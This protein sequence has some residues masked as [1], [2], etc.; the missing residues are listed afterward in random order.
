MKLLDDL[1]INKTKKFARYMIGQPQKNSVVTPLL[2]YYQRLQTE[3]YFSVY[4]LVVLILFL[5]HFIFSYDEEKVVALCLLT[6]GVLSYIN[7]SSL[8][9]EGLNQKSNSL[10]LEFKTLFTEKITA[11][12]RLRIYWRLFM[13]LHDF[14]IEF[15][16]WFKQRFTAIVKRRILNRQNLALH[17]IKAKYSELLSKSLNNKRQ[18]NLVELETTKKNVFFSTPV[19][20]DGY[21]KMLKQSSSST[22]QSFV[23]LTLKNLNI[24]TSSSS[25]VSRLFY[26][27]LIF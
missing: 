16:F 6:F 24:N 5:S 26:F 10:E 18:I 27:T 23:L 3:K 20:F 9:F 15:Y 8:I 13:D 19:S 25:G 21:L 14:L 11:M 12:R 7:F 2:N 22:S 1:F 17:N 4:V